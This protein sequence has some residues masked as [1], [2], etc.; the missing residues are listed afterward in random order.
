MEHKETFRNAKVG[1]KVWNFNTKEWEEIVRII[2]NNIYQIITDRSAYTF[3][4]FNNSTH[5]NPT[6]FPNEFKIPEEAFEKPLPKLEVDTKVIVWDNV[7]GQRL[8]QYFAHFSHNN[9]F[10]C[11]ANGR[12][13]FTTNG[14]VVYWDNWELYKEED[15]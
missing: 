5:K 9:K 11:F 4:G 13:S 8:P 14:V 10:G 3:E 12:T 6:I 15:K 2:Y 1:D 7:M